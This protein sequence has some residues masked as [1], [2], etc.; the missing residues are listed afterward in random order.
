MTITERLNVGE[1]IDESDLEAA[2]NAELHKL[3]GDTRLPESLRKAAREIRDRRVAE[4]RAA[5][6]RLGLV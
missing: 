5:R 4:K 2:R 3:E 6:E 1:S